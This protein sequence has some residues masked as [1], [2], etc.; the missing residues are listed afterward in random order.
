MLA[1]KCTQTNS[2]ELSDDANLSIV[3]ASD[4]WSII[5]NLIYKIKWDSEGSKNILHILEE[6]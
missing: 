3:R 4:G 6:Q 2:S 5:D 1:L